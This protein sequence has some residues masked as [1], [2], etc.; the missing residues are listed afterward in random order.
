MNK[1]TINPNKKTKI[2]YETLIKDLV[3]LNYQ[4]THMVLEP[5]EFSVRGS[6]IDVFAVGLQEPIRF[7]FMGDEPESEP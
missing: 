7:E 3:T 5:G 4:R 1:L 2:G 6:I